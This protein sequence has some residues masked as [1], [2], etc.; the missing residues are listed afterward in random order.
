[1]IV[2]SL[3]DQ[4]VIDMF[5]RKDVVFDFEKDKESFIKHMDALKVQDVQEATLYKKWVELKQFDNTKDVVATG[6]VK[7][8][9]WAPTDIFDKEKTIEEINNLKPQI[10]IAMKELSSMICGSI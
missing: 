10:I 8:M 2:N 9:L 3:T 1:M 7:S 5:F 6:L 4:S